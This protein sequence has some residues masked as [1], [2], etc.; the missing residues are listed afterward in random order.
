MVVPG[1][2]WCDQDR[3]SEKGVAHT[4]A[5]WKK[6]RSIIWDRYVCAF[7][8]PFQTSRRPL[9]PAGTVMKY[10]QRDTKHFLFRDSQLA[11]AASWVWDPLGQVELKNRQEHEKE[12]KIRRAESHPF[13][14]PGCD[15]L[16][17][18]QAMDSWK[19]KECPVLPQG[20]RNVWRAPMCVRGCWAVHLHAPSSSSE[21]VWEHDST[22]WLQHF[23]R[24]RFS[25]HSCTCTSC[26]LPCLTLYTLIP[27]KQVVS[28]QLAAHF[29]R[30]ENIKIHKKIRKGLKITVWNFKVVRRYVY[31]RFLKILCRWN[32][33]WGI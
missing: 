1:W 15:A 16:L 32:W 6:H 8:C 29:K 20:R 7:L 5:G 21:A 26:D 9:E 12:R 23:K 11:Q 19:H 24:G 28:A 3:M 25:G 10:L 2:N 13:S 30:Y 31:G 17:Q 14:S 27:K 4:H 22:L 18:K 33:L